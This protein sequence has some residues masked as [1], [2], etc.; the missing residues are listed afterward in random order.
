MLRQYTEEQTQQPTIVVDK[1]VKEIYEAAV[2]N[3]HCWASIVLNG[4][5]TGYQRMELTE[6]SAAANTYGVTFGGVQ[7]DDGAGKPVVLIGEN[8]NYGEKE[9]DIW[10][11]G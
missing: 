3:K 11:P 5:I 7:N 4:V 2:L 10:T 8:T 6:A 1:S 9:S